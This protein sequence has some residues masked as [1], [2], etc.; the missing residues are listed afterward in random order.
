MANN[1]GT[2]RKLVLNG[3]SYDV[4]ADINITINLS[5]FE[6]EGIPTS[7]RTMHKMTRRVPTM[8]GVVLITNPS[9]ADT[10][11][12][13]AEGLADITMSVELAGGDTYKAT[14]KINYE[15]FE[16]EE[17]R[18]SLTLIPGKTKNAWTLFKA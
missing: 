12:N 8:E 2:I 17:N 6:I 13:L 4:P 1:S 7:G 9:E 3:V 5:S 18:S 16:T 10:L 15:N 11:K 14:G